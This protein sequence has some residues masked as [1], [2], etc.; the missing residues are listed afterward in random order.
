MFSQ[1]EVDQLPQPLPPSSS[2]L[3]SLEFTGDNSI[4]GLLPPPPPPPPLPPAFRFPL[5]LPPSAALSPG[6]SAASL[7]PLPRPLS[8]QQRHL[9]PTAFGAE[10]ATGRHSLKAGI[11]AAAPQLMPLY[12][13]VN[14]QSSVGLRRM[15]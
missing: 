11:S 7:Q 4:L 3:Q 9:T 5:S 12:L 13:R 15:E 2:L 14:S 8:Q 6:L 10:M 1:Q